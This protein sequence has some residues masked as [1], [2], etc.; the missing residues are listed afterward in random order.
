MGAHHPKMIKVC[1]PGSLERN[2]AACAAAARSTGS[3]NH[4]L[5]TETRCPRHLGDI[6]STYSCVLHSALLPSK[7]QSVKSN[8]FKPEA[9]L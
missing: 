2:E 7:P 1:R 9:A 4:V 6:S 3:C 8:A 5:Q